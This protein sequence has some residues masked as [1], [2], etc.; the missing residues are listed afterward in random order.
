MTY[1]LLA[2]SI[3][4]PDLAE[5]EGPSSGE[6]DSAAEDSAARP[7][8]SDA[9]YARDH[10]V[11]VE[12]TL[13]ADDWTALRQ[14][15]RSVLEMF[16]GQC[17]D[18]P[19]ESPFTWFT[20]QVTVDGTAYAEV[21]VRKKGL[22]G[23]L[24]EARP[25]LKIRLDK[26]VDDVEWHGIRRLVLN[27]GRQD[28]SRLRTCLAYDTWRDAGALAPRCTLAHVTVNDEDLGVYALVE[29]VDE[30]FME[31]NVGTDEVA[32]YEGTLSDFRDGWTG[33]FEPETGVSDLH[34][35]LAL[36]E[37][38]ESGANLDELGTVLDV[39]AFLEHWALEGLS[40][41]WDG[42]AANTNNFYVFADPSSGLLRFVPWGPDASFTAADAFGEGAPTWIAANAALPRVA[43]GSDGGLGRYRDHLRAAIDR[44][45]DTDRKLGDVDQLAAL[46]APYGDATWESEVATLRRL[47][48]RR[49]D[50][51]LDAIDDPV[52]FDGDLRDP[53][54]FVEHGSASGTFSTTW[55]SYDGSDPF[56]TGDVTLEVEYDGNPVPIVSGGAVAGE[57]RGYAVLLLATV[58]GDRE[59]L[60]P[61]FQ[62]APE[63]MAPGTVSL[64][65]LSAT[66]G[67]YYYGPDTGGEYVFSGYLAGE[68]VLEEASTD[69]GGA[70]SGSFTST[71]LQFGR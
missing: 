34:E 3:T 65:F 59:Y 13:S 56:S 58:I 29:P 25:S 7:D 52:G 28:P 11:E 12:V 10:L 53:L 62:L 46:A 33:T 70:I 31:R 44:G 63:D 16:D 23:S 61:Y 2:C 8:G 37:L 6:I 42:Y 55:G 38:A 49:A 71:L 32:L 64:D 27:N 50:D 66:G 4:V 57:D 5:A 21:G 45:W 35:V 9:A 30:D 47:V 39:E 69:R 20:G 51:V 18:E 14:Q 43:L 68:L 19:F 60:V 26:Y 48:K 15:D 1:A 54:C 22:L 41:H 24:D 36:T 40:G 67:L 17:M